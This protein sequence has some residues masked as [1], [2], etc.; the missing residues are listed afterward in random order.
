MHDQAQLMSLEIDPVIPHAKPVQ[1]SA[2]AFELA[3]LVQ[4]GPQDLLGQAAEFAQDFE[5]Q[6]FWHPGQLGRAGGVKDDL[7]KA[8]I[9]RVR[10]N[11]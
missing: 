11:T 4:L 6:I 1:R 5:L 10:N 2:R 7:E 3:K 9:N 8:H